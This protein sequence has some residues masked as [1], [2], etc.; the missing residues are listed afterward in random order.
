MAQTITYVPILPK[1]FNGTVFLPEILSEMQKINKDISKDFD[2][3]TA[4]WN[5]AEKPT[6]D[7]STTQ[8]SSQTVTEVT[9]K[10]HIYRFVNNGT[11][12][13][14]ATMTPDF[15][16]KTVP[17]IIDSGRGSGGLKYVSKKV[18]R[19]GIVARHFDIEI[20]KIWEK[21]FGTRMQAA[22]NRAAA[23]TGHKI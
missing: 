6:W 16:P 20:K 19:P 7:K 18:P 3:T 1:P 22:I 23:K 2:R 4:T 13:R 15:K 11:S 8:S 17:G 14:Y 5:A 21:P 10:S 9:T 12:V